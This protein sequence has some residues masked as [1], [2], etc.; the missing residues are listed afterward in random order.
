MQN[1]HPI[2]RIKMGIAVIRFI[3]S[4]LAKAAV[5]PLECIMILKKTLKEGY[6]ITDFLQFN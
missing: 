5:L 3:Y 4:V 1:L 6:V 2:L